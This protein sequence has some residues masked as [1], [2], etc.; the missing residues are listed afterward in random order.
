M[1]RSASA[2]SQ[3]CWSGTGQ[4]GAG[5]WVEALRREAAG[6]GIVL[7]L[8]P[9]LAVVLAADRSSD[10]ARTAHVVGGDEGEA[11]RH[12][13]GTHPEDRGERQERRRQEDEHELVAQ[14]HH[15]P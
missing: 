8:L 1:K 9:R 3:N 12:Q 7:Q 2:L 10:V 5:R 15:V 13:R 11:A 4:L 14:A 6:H